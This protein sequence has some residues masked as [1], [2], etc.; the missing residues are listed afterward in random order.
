[1]NKCMHRLARCDDAGAF[2]KTAVAYLEDNGRSWIVTAD[3][4]G[5]EMAVSKTFGEGFL[6]RFNATPVL[7]PVTH[8]VAGLLV[9]RVC[10]C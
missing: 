5:I 10:A 1:M 4:M 2:V 9:R 6:H 7:R 8:C 3:E